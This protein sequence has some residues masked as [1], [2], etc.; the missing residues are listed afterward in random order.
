MKNKYLLVKLQKK[1]KDGGYALVS[2]EKGQVFAFADN[3]SK[4]YEIIDAK[5]IEDENKTVMYVPPPNVKHVFH[6][7]LSIRFH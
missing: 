7:S 2:L 5:N 1:Y 4:L 3:L 6:I